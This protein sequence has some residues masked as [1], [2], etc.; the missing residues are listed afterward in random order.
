MGV[1]EKTQ[2][3]LQTACLV[4]AVAILLFFWA[5]RNYTTDWRER[6]IFRRRLADTHRRLTTKTKD[7]DDK[8]EDRQRVQWKRFVAAVPLVPL[9]TAYVAARL[10]W[11]VFELLVFCGIDGMRHTSVR[12]LEIIKISWAVLRRSLAEAARRL[13]M[14]QRLQQMVIAAVENTVVWLFHSAAPAIAHALN[15]VTSG[16]EVAA[17]WW[18]RVDG[19]SRLRDAIEA[20]VLDGLVPGIEAMQKAVVA[21]YVRVSWLIG[22]TIE[23]IVILGTDLI[24]DVR[25]LAT[26]TAALVSWLCCDQRWWRDPA[27]H[28]AVVRV[29]SACVDWLSRMY[30]L[31]VSRVVPL[32]GKILRLAQA[33]IIKSGSVCWRAADAVLQQSLGIGIRLLG[34]MT[35]VAATMWYWLLQVDVVSPLKRGLHAISRHIHL[36]KQVLMLA[37]ALGGDLHAW[38]TAHILVPIA[39]LAGILAM[40]IGIAA[41]VGMAWIVHTVGTPL[42]S[43]LRES[44][45]LAELALGA[46]VAWITAVDFSRAWLLVAACW[47]S[48]VFSDL[49]QITREWALSTMQM[50]ATASEMLWPLLSR[51]WRDAARAMADVYAQLAALV[52]SA[53]ALVG[54]LIVE[55]ARQNTV[56]SPT[57]PLKSSD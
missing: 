32:L 55:Y 16:A 17:R 29:V 33:I 46:A 28:D 30:S 49:V 5:A 54:D 22:C 24:R 3:N 51:G 31:A 26:W 25:V 1:R 4:S 41:Q 9:A 42:L 20:A 11:D 18:E 40:R 13:D 44:V 35:P 48:A 12:S 23:A 36:L 45:R 34:S 50:L 7:K 37:V 52:D 38:A 15:Q 57:H 19:A 43:G 27:L 2:F 8:E 10:G 21:T 6:R 56:H 14:A 53:A 39:H 47:P